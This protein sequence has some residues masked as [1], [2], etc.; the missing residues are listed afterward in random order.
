MDVLYNSGLLVAMVFGMVEY[1]RLGGRV[2]YISFMGS[3]MVICRVTAFLL[4]LLLFLIGVPF[5]SSRISGRL[6]SP[7]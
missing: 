5:L 7:K 6:L 4:E 3:C 1:D 2:K